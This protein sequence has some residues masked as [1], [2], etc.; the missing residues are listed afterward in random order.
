MRK[1]TE[2]YGS[3]KEK[4]KLFSQA[5]M[6]AVRTAQNNNLPLTY[7]SKN[8]VIKE[9]PDGRKQILVTLSDYSQKIPK[10]FTIK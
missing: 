2:S 4:Q 9:Y 3:R 10:K 1:I 6:I 7:V 5:G 8:E